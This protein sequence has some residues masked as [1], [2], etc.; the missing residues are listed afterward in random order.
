MS[1]N[2]KTFHDAIK[3]T[4]TASAAAQK[5]DISRKTF[6]QWKR[7]YDC[8]DAPPHFMEAFMNKQIDISTLQW[9][10]NNHERCTPKELSKIIKEQ[11]A[12]KNEFY[13]SVQVARLELKSVKD[14]LRGMRSGGK[15]KEV[16]LF[17]N[18]YE[19]RKVT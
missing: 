14:S 15:V 10:C 6:Y 9:S 12:L 8:N 19:I 7:I 17:G 13:I 3:T 1:Y 16:F 4:S 11:A 2:Y 18:K 5:L